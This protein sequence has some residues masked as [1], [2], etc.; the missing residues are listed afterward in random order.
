MMSTEFLVRQA[1]NVR[2]ASIS[3]RCA[4]TQA[5]GNNELWKGIILGSVRFRWSV[6]TV[7]YG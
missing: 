4:V 3:R 2:A 6:T 7:F 5:R 1:D